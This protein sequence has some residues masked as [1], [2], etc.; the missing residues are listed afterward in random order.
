MR[1]SIFGRVCHFLQHRV[2]LYRTPL[3][4]PNLNNG[5]RLAVRFC[6]SFPSFGCDIIYCFFFMDRV[7]REQPPPPSPFSTER[8]LRFSWVRPFFCFITDFFF[9]WTG[10]FPFPLFFVLQT[11]LFWTPSTVHIR[12]FFVACCRHIAF[13][14]TVFFPARRL[15]SRFGD[16][17]LLPQNSDRFPPYL[18][19]SFFSLFFFVFFPFPLYIVPKFLGH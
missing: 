10:F 9:R 1:L 14:T 18:L 6:D 2:T 8:T 15:R 12:P 7:P 3:P 19:L 16:A 4:L 5:M 13:F 11:D 17:H